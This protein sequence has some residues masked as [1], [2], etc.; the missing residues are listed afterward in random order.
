MTVPPKT[1]E[2][3]LTLFERARWPSGPVCPY[4]HSTKIARHASPDREASRWQCQSCRR[5]FSA[6][7][8]TPFQ[9]SHLS[10][11]VWMHLLVRLVGSAGELNISRLSDEIPLRRG[12]AAKALK[13]L[14]N[15]LDDDDDRSF[16]FSL[17]DQL[18][19]S[20]QRSIYRKH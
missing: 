5:A 12:T 17:I 13:R 15:I 20:S 3:A 9:G 14:G 18:D 8:G 7:V 16:A 2:Q 1:D 19:R 4:C 10:A 6:M 11:R